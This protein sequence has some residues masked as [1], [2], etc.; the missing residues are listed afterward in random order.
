MDKGLIKERK[1]ELI[2]K[3]AYIIKHA[4]DPILWHDFT[5]DRFLEVCMINVNAIE[6][7]IDKIKRLTPKNGN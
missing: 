2:K 3:F 5:D 6:I 4:A 1:K 7:E